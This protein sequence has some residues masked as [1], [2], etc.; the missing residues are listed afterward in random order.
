MCNPIFSREI[1]PAISEFVLIKT[2][3][4][5]YPE[6]RICI[7]HND[8]FVSNTY[9][10]FRVPFSEERTH[11]LEIFL[12]LLWPGFLWFHL[13]TYTWWGREC[14]SRTINLAVRLSF[15]SKFYCWTYPQKH[16]QYTALRN[17]HDIDVMRQCEII[18]MT[19]T[20][21]AMRA[22][23]LGKLTTRCICCCCCCWCYWCEYVGGSAGASSFHLLIN[24]R[25]YV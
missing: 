2:S 14:L 15:F 11:Y 10:R 1:G 13:C 5:L 20:G 9:F 17:K 6:H 8:P 19:V 7:P 3:S 12:P 18:G 25:L 22:N 24:F 23:L 4:S 21:A 16:H